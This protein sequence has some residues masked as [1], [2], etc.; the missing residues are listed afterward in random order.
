MS[1]CDPSIGV[2]NLTLDTYD[3]TWRYRALSGWLDTDDLTVTAIRSFLRIIRLIG[4]SEFQL[5]VRATNDQN[6]P[7]SFT[8]VG[9]TISTVSSSVETVDISTIT[10]NKLFVQF[11]IAYRTGLSAVNGQAD[12]VVFPKG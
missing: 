11:G 10:A 5:C 8:A 12:L 4:A 9:S 6:N 1:A 2:F 3:A 7:G